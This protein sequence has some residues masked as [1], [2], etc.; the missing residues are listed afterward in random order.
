[1]FND[2][3]FQ[4]S[5]LFLFIFFNHFDFFWAYFVLRSIFSTIGQMFEK[6]LD[7]MDHGRILGSSNLNQH[8]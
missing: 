3:N 5:I 2:I 7:T 8:G 6:V 4:K 1:M